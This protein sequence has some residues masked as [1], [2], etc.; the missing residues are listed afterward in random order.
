VNKA[1]LLET[2]F[3]IGLKTTGALLP[4]L[5]GKLALDL[6]CSPFSRPLSSGAR[7]FLTTTE[8]H[9]VH[10]GDGTVVTFEIGSGPAV[11]MAHG[12]AAHGASMRAFVPTLVDC[13]YRV[14]LVDL[15]A[16]GESSDRRTNLIRASRSI[17][18]VLRERGPFLGAIAHSFG[19]P[20]LL[21]TLEREDVPPLDRLVTVGSPSNMSW[22]VSSFCQRFEVPT[23]AEANMRSRVDA[24]FQTSFADHDPSATAAHFGDRLL[25]VHDRR[26]PDVDLAQG[27]VMAGA[28]GIL[29]ETDGLGHNRVLRDPEVIKIVAGFLAGESVPTHSSVK[30]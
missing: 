28:K 12:W 11:L 23:R 15:P 25:V 22:V 9:D 27:R 6:F 14:V 21:L 20:A 5:G 1:E 17:G 10:W 24:I 18:A 26:D 8:R 30:V 29:L 16:H 19:A 7:K 2:V 4:P 3:R 13:G